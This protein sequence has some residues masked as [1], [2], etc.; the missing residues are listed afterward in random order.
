MIRGI[1]PEA[2]SVGEI[3]LLKNGDIIEIDVEKKKINV[4]ISKNELNERKSQMKPFK[5]KVKRGWLARYSS[6]VSSADSGA[7]LS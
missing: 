1:S 3:G 5:P 2:A 6:M 7:V 4:K